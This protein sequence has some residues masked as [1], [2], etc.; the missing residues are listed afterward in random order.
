MKLRN[1]FVDHGLQETFHWGNLIEL[2][3]IFAFVWQDLHLDCT[4][5]RIVE[6]VIVSLVGR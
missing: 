5:V 3:A 4:I 2:V 6:A 1:N